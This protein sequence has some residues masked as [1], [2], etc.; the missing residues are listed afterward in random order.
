MEALNNKKYIPTEKNMS[1]NN[2]EHAPNPSHQTPY[3][4]LG[5][6]PGADLQ[7]HAYLSWTKPDY[8]KE[9]KTRRK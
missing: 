1:P 9:L 7:P 5:N 6:F 2:Q 3:D 4:K 8:C